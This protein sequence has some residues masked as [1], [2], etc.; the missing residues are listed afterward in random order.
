MSTLHDVS[1]TSITDDYDFIEDE[2]DDD[3]YPSLG[4]SWYLV[5]PED[6]I[7]DPVLES[8]TTS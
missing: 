7:V 1:L 8:V 2:V 4:E 6:Y 3:T 5:Q